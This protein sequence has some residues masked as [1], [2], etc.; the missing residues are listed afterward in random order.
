LEIGQAGDGKDKLDACVAV[1]VLRVADAQKHLTVGAV[2]FDLDPLLV[3][4]F[5]I[6]DNIDGG[7]DVSGHRNISRHVYDPGAPP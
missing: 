5:T 3:S 2:I 6:G 4:T 1:T 7:T